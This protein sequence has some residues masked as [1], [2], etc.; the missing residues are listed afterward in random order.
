M[1]WSQA[2]A[3]AE[4]LEYGGYDDWRLPRV[5]D[6][7]TSGCNWA[8]SGTDCG[9][10]VDTST[11]ELAY[12]WYENLGNIAFVGT[13]GSGTQ[14]GW[15]LSST[16]ADGVDILNLQPGAYWSGTEYAPGTTHAWWFYAY[17]G[18]Q[19]HHYK[20]DLLS[21]WAVRTGDVAPVP[22]PGS[23]LLMLTGLASL[24]VVKWRRC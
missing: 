19:R 22:I 10:N 7:G 2:M 16:S 18:Q 6:T 15:G 17:T 23:L 12:M 24:G 21:A 8:V 11:S 4:G 3:W 1:I 9:F 13:S 14:S 20:N 5:I